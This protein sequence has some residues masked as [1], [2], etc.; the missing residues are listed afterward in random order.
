MSCS[1][2]SSTIENELLMKLKNW[3]L[4]KCPIESH[5]APLEL[6][7]VDP[8]CQQEKFFDLFCVQCQT[9]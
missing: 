3:I 4:P 7:C 2:Y 9:H 8:K 1:T 5:D 6:I